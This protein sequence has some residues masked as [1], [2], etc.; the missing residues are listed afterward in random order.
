MRTQSML[1]KVSLA[2]GI[3]ISSVLATTFPASAFTYQFGKDSQSSNDL[4][5][6]AAA[7]IDFKF[8]DLGSNQLRIDLKIKNTTGEDTFG[9]GAKTSKLTGIAFDMFEGFNLVSSNLGN[10]LDTL[11]T[12]VSFTPFSN[13]VGNFDFALADNNSF[14]GGNPNGALD[15]GFTDDV[16]LVYSGLNGESAVDFE[17]RFAAAF[18][19]GELDIASRFQVVNAGAGSDKLLGGSIVGGIPKP[20]PTPEAESVPEPTGLLGLGLFAG[21]LIMLGKRKHDQNSE[22]ALPMNPTC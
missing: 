14:E 3:G 22:F 17:A 1:S 7:T 9:S 18:A 6:G 8:Q 4:A 12:N 13:T 21:G 5:T 2:L 11:L 10:Q 16:F 15:Q 20:E 19:S